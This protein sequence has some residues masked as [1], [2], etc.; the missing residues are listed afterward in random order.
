MPKI[1]KLLYLLLFF[2]AIW[3]LIVA[4]N[5]NN[6]L[7]LIYLG[8]TLTA[9]FYIGKDKERSI[10]LD[11]TGKWIFPIAQ[12]IFIYAF[13]VI[14]ASFLLPLFEKI[15]VGGLLR[16][17][18]SSSPAL[19]DSQILN[20]ISFVLSIPFVE[21]IFFI[22]MFDYLATWMKI[23][24]SRK[25]LFKFGTWILMIGVALA[26]LFFH[27]TAKGITNNGA[28]MLVFFMMMVTLFFAVLF[29]ESKQVIGF[30]M[31][32]NG[33]ALNLFGILGSLALFAPIMIIKSKRFKK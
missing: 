20:T 22:V 19:A 32:A 17:I 15:N 1:D 30:H 27:V 14:A 21:T 3:F 7:G 16:L 8:F 23:D 10:P 31:I 28:L 5:V 26:F 4:V 33:V 18:A 11:R 13:F 25:G 2:S 6:I 24:I 9:A 12:A 29:G